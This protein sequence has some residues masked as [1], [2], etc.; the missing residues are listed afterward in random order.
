MVRNRNNY[1]HPANQI[2]SRIEPDYTFI[3]IKVVIKINY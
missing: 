3:F 1:L 2:K